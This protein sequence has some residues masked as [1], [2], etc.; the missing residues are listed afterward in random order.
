MPDK[1]WPPPPPP[2]RDRPGLGD[3]LASRLAGR[4]MLMPDA[5]RGSVTWRAYGRT[6]VS[7][8]ELNAATVEPTWYWT[9]GV[10]FPDTYVEHAAPAVQAH[11]DR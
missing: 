3:A 9:S 8:T 7:C 10:T 2:P 5:L 11:G 4:L 1:S 6:R